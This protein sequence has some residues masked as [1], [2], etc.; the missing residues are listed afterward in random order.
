M[1]S[2]SSLPWVA[3][4]SRQGSSQTGYLCLQTSTPKAGHCQ[5]QLIGR[6]TALERKRTHSAPLAYF[7]KLIP[8]PGLT[9]VS[10]GGR[11]AAVSART[12]SPVQRRSVTLEEARRRKGEDVGP[13]PGSGRKR[14]VAQDGHP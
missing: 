3:R 1:V 14:E 5:K 11:V 2:T 7:S 6:R 9:E 8:K 13:K 12:L 4:S 10:Y